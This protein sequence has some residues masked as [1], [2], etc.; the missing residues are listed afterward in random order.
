MDKFKKL[1]YGIVDMAIA[2]GWVRPLAYYCH[3]ITLFGNG[4]IYN[5]SSRTLGEKLGRSHN[6]VNENVK[7]L[8]NKGLL[9]LDGNHLKSVSVSKIRDLVKDFT[10]KETGKGLITIKVHKNNLKHTEWNILARVPLNNLRRQKHLSSKR[11]EV[12]AIRT[13]L[14]SSTAYVSPKE[15]KRVRDFDESLRN[16]KTEKARVAT[17]ELCYLSDSVIGKL[18]NGRSVASVR[19]MIKFWEEQG[20]LKPTLHKGRVLDTHITPRSFEALVAEGRYSDVY[21]YKGKVI[22]FNKRS[23]DF[24]DSIKPRISKKGENKTLYRFLKTERIKKER[25]ELLAGICMGNAYSI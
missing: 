10:G 13:K 18:M 8:L 2:E 17:G 3:I 11:A 22:E 24:G 6:A 16:K 20:L 9:T 7:F 5:Y 21:Y 19:A 4:I 15:N 12:D 1:P 14:K 25:E 23:F